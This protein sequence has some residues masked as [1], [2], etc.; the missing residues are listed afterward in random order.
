MA[1]D[2]KWRNL[3][4]MW[5]G[6]GIFLFFFGLFVLLPVYQTWQESKTDRAVVLSCATAESR[7][8]CVKEFK[9]ALDE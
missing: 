1:D 9:K 3:R 8:A 4:D 2:E 6:L 5:A 7:A